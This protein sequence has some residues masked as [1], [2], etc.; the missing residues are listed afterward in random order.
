M[1]EKIGDIKH[2]VEGHLLALRGND[3]T[4]AGTTARSSPSTSS[5]TA[6]TVSTEATTSSATSS[7]TAS[8]VSTE[9]TAS[10]ATS[11]TE[12]ATSSTIVVTRGSVID[13]AVAATDVLTV[14]G[15]EGL[16]SRVDVGELDVG[17]ALRRAGLA[18]RRETDRG[19]LAVG[20]EGLPEGVLVRVERKVANPLKEEGKEG[21]EKTMM[22]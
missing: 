3:A 17:E 13:A 6:S 22:T 19:D 11:S 8:A 18:I 2:L 12:A 9:A 21:Q 4:G 10:S 16:G 15:L 7:T 20:A 1:S 14:E 5:T